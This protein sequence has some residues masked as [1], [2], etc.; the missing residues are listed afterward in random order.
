[1]PPRCE[2]AARPVEHA[3]WRD[4]NVAR[5]Y[6]GPTFRREPHA[7]QCHEHGGELP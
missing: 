1:M 6:D 5:L 2:L 7:F 3:V 4:R